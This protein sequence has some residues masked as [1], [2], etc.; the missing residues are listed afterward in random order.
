L[1]VAA[2]A[3]LLMLPLAAGMLGGCAAQFADAPLVGLPANAPARPERPSAYMPVHDVPPPREE[4]VP[5]ADE[6]TNLRK[7]LQVARDKQ[8]AK[9]DDLARQK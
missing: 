9:A 7:E 4:P 5:T 2:R 6:Q 3:V 1:V 8:K